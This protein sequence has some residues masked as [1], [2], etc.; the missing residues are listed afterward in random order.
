MQSWPTRLL[1]IPWRYLIRRRWDQPSFKESWNR[2]CMWSWHS[3]SSVSLCC[4][5][6]VRATNVRILRHHIS[7]LCVQQLRRV[8]YGVDMRPVSATWDNVTNSKNICNLFSLLYF[9]ALFAESARSLSLMGFNTDFCSISFS[10][11]VLYFF[12]SFF[13][14]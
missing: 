8:W 2:H 14:L 3:D 6:S 13:F 1:S 11:S 4:C 9:Y 7:M 5:V 10:F 12:L